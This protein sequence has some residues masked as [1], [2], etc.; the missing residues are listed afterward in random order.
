MVRPWGLA[1]SCRARDLPLAEQCSLRGRLRE[2]SGRVR[3]AVEA[4]NAA[5]LIVSAIGIVAIDQACKS[6][7]TR[8]LVEGR[9]YGVSGRYG[10]RRT[11]SRGGVL[12][13]SDRQ[14]L[15]LWLGALAYLLVL[16]AVGASLFDP[17]TA[18]GLGL[19]LGGATSNLAD[20]PARGEVV[21]F[22]ALGPWPTFNLADV[23]LVTGLL[24]IAAGLL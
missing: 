4:M 10:V 24:L 1:A 20:G 21:D 19:S 18:V 3:L 23:A 6:M 5:L 12:D 8:L 22:V 17:A 7:V 9:V 14:A 11:G 13:L 15:A 16:L 2:A